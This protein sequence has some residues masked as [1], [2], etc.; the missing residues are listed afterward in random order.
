MSL[1]VNKTISTANTPVLAGEI[2]PAPIALAVGSI[3]ILNDSDSAAVVSVYISL[4]S[5][6]VRTDL[7]ESQCNIPA[8]GSLSIEC[9]QLAPGE[10][11]FVLANNNDCITR[12]TAIV[13]TN[14]I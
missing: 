10:K 13:K 12:F 2:G 8:R 7:I 9:S 4:S 6:P 11:V 1:I 3:N 14:S 5:S